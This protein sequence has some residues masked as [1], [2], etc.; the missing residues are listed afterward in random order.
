MQ[1]LGYGP[2]GR[3]AIRAYV[4]RHTNTF[5]GDFN[6][7]MIDARKAVFE[8]AAPDLPLTSLALEYEVDADMSPSQH[9]HKH[10]SVNDH[11]SYHQEIGLDRND[12]EDKDMSV[13]KDNNAHDKTSAG[14]DG[15]GSRVDKD[16][17][18]RFL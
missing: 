18:G 8:Q 14:Q 3:H 11:D 2:H 17:P 5:H 15:R 4:K 13:D 7:R 12:G 1:K 10:Q 9:E 6:Q 16:D